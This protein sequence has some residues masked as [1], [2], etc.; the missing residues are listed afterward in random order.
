MVRTSPRRLFSFPVSF[1]ASFGRV[2]GPKQALQ[3]T[4]LWRRCADTVGASLQSAMTILEL[5]S[6][7]LNCSE[8]SIFTEDDILP[9]VTRSSVWLGV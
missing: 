3:T 8:D 7:P 9:V 6:R 4:G 1:Y 2:P 5:L